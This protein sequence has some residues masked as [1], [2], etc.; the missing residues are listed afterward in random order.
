MSSVIDAREQFQGLADD[1]DAMSIDHDPPGGMDLTRKPLELAATAA[2]FAMVA[3]KELDDRVAAVSAYTKDALQTG[4]KLAEGAAWA[5]GIV[6]AK[7]AKRLLWPNG[8]TSEQT[9][10]SVDAGE[11]ELEP[12]EVLVRPDEKKNL[13]ALEKELSGPNRPLA[14][15][16]LASNTAFL[17]TRHLEKLGITHPAARRERFKSE[18]TQ[19]T[20]LG[21]EAAEHLAKQVESILGPTKPPGQPEGPDKASSNT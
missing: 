4:T 2:I 20:H 12:E 15:Y 19:E 14:V 18:I 6:V 1:V 16:T 10:E 7:G 8:K 11:E 13:T 9:D 17:I 5:S 21:E 3:G